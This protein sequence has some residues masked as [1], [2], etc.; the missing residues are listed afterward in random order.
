M[1]PVL[2][3]P[4]PNAETLAPTDP[5]ALSSLTMTSRPIYRAE[6]LVGDATGP[7]NEVQI[8]STH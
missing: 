2:V 1:K 5:I 3:S 7:P 6:F 4:I 8:P